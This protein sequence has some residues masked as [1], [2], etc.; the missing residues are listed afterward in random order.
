MG[1]S[2]NGEPEQEPAEGVD[3]PLAG[4]A[5]DPSESRYKRRVGISLATLAVLAAFI[6]F[7]QT[8]ASNNEA[9]TARQATRLAAE[10]QTADVLSKGIQ[11]GLNEVDAELSLLPDREVFGDTEGIAS[12]FGVQVDPDRAQQR[13]AQ[14][15]EAIEQSL[16]ED[17]TLS[18]EFDTEAQRLSL[19]QALVV[20]QR[21]SWNA[22]ASQYDT[23][24]TVLAVAIFLVGFT[25]VVGRNLRPPL[26]IP[27]MILAL[28]CAGWA[29][30]IYFKPTPEVS[31]EAIDATA[32]GRYLQS[33]GDTQAAIGQF[34][35]AL[36]ST[37]DYTEALISRALSGVLEA[38]PDLQATLAWTDTSAEVLDRAAADVELA[39]DSGAQEDP[40]AWAVAA[41]VAVG[42][43]DWDAAAEYLEEGIRLNELAAELY[44][45][46]AAVAAGQGDVDAARDWL[47]QAQANFGDLGEDRIRTL[48]AQYL[49]L[50]EYVAAVDPDQA[51][52]ASQLEEGG[53]AALAESR[54]GSPLVAGSS[55][56]AGFTGANATFSDDNTTVDLDVTGIDD[57][58]QIVIAGFEDPGG[59]NG[60]V[61]SPELFYSG[62][63]G[64]GREGGVTIR[65]PRNCAPTEF[66]FD[67]YVEG[68]FRD[69][70]T[71]PGGSATC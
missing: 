8:G 45:W 68:E 20:E 70:T 62:P 2:A 5:D 42:R 35:T 19:E 66:R 55:P 26:A 30:Q 25:L 29:A 56:D 64:Q 27:G 46:R 36:E 58:A 43:G 69:S 59:G 12:Q 52:I 31:R 17:R 54:K 10:A 18:A 40:T 32:E 33:I 48:A 22:K 39:I 21:V 23:V 28:V 50:L 6:A 53:I 65:T 71:V 9:A 47:L 61:Q 60:W 37:P 44:L 38:N 51:D 4:E 49:T 24:L 57:G 1:D 67:L 7:V 14:A 3:V 11:S 41:V 15:E 34:D 63:A 13:S 16:G